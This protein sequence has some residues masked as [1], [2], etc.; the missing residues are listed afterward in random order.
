VVLAADEARQSPGQVVA[1]TLRWRQR[2]RVEARVLDQQRLLERTQGRRRLDAQ[3]LGQGVSG[4]LKRAKRIGLPPASVQREHEL[5]PAVLAQRL[6]FH[7]P[8]Q[9][10]DDQLVTA[11][12]QLHVGPQLVRP[13]PELLEPSDVSPEP[14]LICE[15]APRAASPK[16][17]RRLHH[18][19][20]PVRIRDGQVLGFVRQ[21]LETVSVDPRPIDLEHIALTTG[22]HDRA[23]P[24]PLVRLQ[25]AP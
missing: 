5:L 18:P 21:R 7:R 13:S 15:R 23:R 1:R 2:R 22:P 3:L 11:Q 20:R 14:R 8:S 19:E 6:L 16:R 10:I 17:T 9:R 24:A 12:R 25:R 4:V